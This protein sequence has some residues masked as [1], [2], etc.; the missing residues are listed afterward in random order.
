MIMRNIGEKRR[1]NEEKK[2]IRR[3]VVGELRKTNQS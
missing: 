1:G 3:G 2:G